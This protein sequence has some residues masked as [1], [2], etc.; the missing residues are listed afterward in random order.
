MRANRKH[1]AVSI[2]CSVTGCPLKYNVTF[3]RAMEISTRKQQT[4]KS[5]FFNKQAFSTIDV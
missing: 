3:R 1:G 4:G 5:L 2:S